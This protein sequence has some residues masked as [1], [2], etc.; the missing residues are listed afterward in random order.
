V[1]SNITGYSGYS[2]YSG[3]TGSNGSAGASGTSGYSGATGTSGFSGYSGSSATGVS[4]LN[5]NTGA[6]KGMDLISTGTISGNVS[7]YN[8]TGIPTGYYMLILYF[9]TKVQNTT[10]ATFGLRISTNNGSSFFTGGYN[11]ATLD[12]TGSIGSGQDPYFKNMAQT[13]GGTG[14]QGYTFSQ[15]NLLQGNAT[16]GVPFQLINSSVGYT[17]N[18]PDSIGFTPI[19][20][21]AYNTTT[22][23]NALQIYK[24]AGSYI[25]SGT[26]TLYG[27]K[28][29]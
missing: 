1:Y 15:Q 9:T 4:S 26:Y 7:T 14:G 18:G 13:A 5:G 3:A 17:V 2:G 29:A 20:V 6:L 23:V 8:I 24:Y 16:T 19:T 12:G 22:Y 27:V 25:V 10:D 21:G 28:N 11:W